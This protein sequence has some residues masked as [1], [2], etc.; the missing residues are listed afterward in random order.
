M[1]QVSRSA[2]ADSPR[3]TEDSVF[4]GEVSQAVTRDAHGLM[5]ASLNSFRDRNPAIRGFKG[6][7]CKSGS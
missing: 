4:C 1:R 7:L 6:E 3:A 2:S 5:R